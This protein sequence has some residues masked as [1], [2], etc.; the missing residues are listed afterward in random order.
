[1]TSAPLRGL[2]VLVTRP[3]H[4]ASEL[5]AKI[6]A[7]GGT[8][9]S[10]PVL[11]IEERPLDAVRAQIRAQPEP[12][13]VVFVSANAV[14]AA[15]AAFTDLADSDTKIAAIGPA[16]AAAVAAAGGAVDLLP[17]SGFQSADLLKLA[18]FKAVAGKNVSIVRGQ[19]GRELL[20]ET[21]RHRGANV[22]YVSAYR[23]EPR[24]PERAETEHVERLW[25]DGGIDAV[26]VM[27]V[28]TLD[29][30]LA[31]L[32]DSALTLLRKT[33]LVAPSERVIQT[34]LERL[35]GVRCIQSPGPTASD[36][37]AALTT[38]LHTDP[39]RNHD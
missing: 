25:R 33:P 14:R 32:P 24:V 16:T 30:L 3:E 34:A 13:I 4:Q 11:R 18:D 10:F 7:L 22:H 31:A 27:S 39:V 28:A 23:R 8:T 26:V 17:P 21:L 37:A 12:D 36:I 9:I 1:M 35:P 19:S 29:A 6:E 15:F 38:G 2:G 5:K 20:A